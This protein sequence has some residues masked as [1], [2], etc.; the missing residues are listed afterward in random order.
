M[1]NLTLVI[2]AKFEATTLPIVLKEIKDLN[3]NCKKIVVVPKYDQETQKALEGT[4]CEVLI[5]KGEFNEYGY[6]DGEWLIRDSLGRNDSIFI[7]NYGY[8]DTVYAPD[9]DT[10]DIDTIDIKPFEL[11]GDEGDNLEEDPLIQTQG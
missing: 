3:L 4:D 9:L 1:E 5:Q 2:P 10:F 11:K 6:R 8:I 7:Y